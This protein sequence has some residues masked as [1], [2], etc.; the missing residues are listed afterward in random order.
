VVGEPGPVEVGRLGEAL[1]EGAV[2]CVAT[3]FVSL[4][5]V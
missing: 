1:K 3:P 4:C 5:K 2:S